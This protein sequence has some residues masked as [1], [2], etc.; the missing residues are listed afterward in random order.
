MRRT[1]HASAQMSW[2]AHNLA[3]TSYGCIRLDR[4]FFTSYSTA[5]GPV[6]DSAPA[7]VIRI[8]LKPLANIFKL[9]AADDGAERVKMS[10][11]EVADRLVCIIHCKHG[12]VKTHSLRLM[13]LATGSAPF[14]LALPPPLDGAV[15]Q[16]TASSKLI[17]TWMSHFPS[18][19]DEVTLLRHPAH[20]CLTSCCEGTASHRSLSTE[21]I[22]DFLDLDNLVVP[23]DG[24][25]EGQTQSPPAIAFNLRDFKAALHLSD[26]LALPLTVEFQ[27][28]GDPLVVQARATEWE[29]D[30]VL[31]TA[32][33]EPGAEA[34]GATPASATRHPTAAPPMVARPRSVTPAPPRRLAATSAHATPIA[35]RAPPI[36]WFSPTDADAMSPIHAHDPYSSVLRVETPAAGGMT[37]IPRAQPT[38][39]GDAEFDELD[40]LPPSPPRM[41]GRASIFQREHIPPPLV[42]TICLQGEGDVCMSGGLD[43]QSQQAVRDVMQGLH[44][45]PGM[46]DDV[47]LSDDDDD[48]ASVAGTPARP[49][50]PS[51]RRLA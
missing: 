21:L 39:R 11:D 20:F 33:E 27:R 48:F 5:P 45:N 43:E 1:T 13:S 49:G 26:A 36:P 29:F 8:A 40:S 28:P 7:P 46:Y 12:V 9:I 22:I 51:G 18:R 30:L 32:A 16:F 17:H 19:L 38:P 31:A 4:S 34:M 35:T 37:G 23:E 47:V 15:G 25:G 24:E 50:P 2:S 6:D 42:Q 14:R 44:E 41:Q 10:L 3:R